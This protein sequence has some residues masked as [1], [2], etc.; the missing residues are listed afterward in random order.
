MSAN[1]KYPA[2]SE[3]QSDIPA[4]ANTVAPLAAMQIAPEVSASAPAVLVLLGLVSSVAILLHVGAAGSHVRLESAVM[5]YLAA[6][7]AL[8]MHPGSAELGANLVLSSPI[9][10]HFIVM[11]APAVHV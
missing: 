2:E 6:S 4:N 3:D 1:K 11:V 9:F 7:V 10:A 8:L 5:S